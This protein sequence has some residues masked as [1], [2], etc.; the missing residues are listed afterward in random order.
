MPPRKIDSGDFTGK[1]VRRLAEAH[2]EDIAAAQQRTGLVNQVVTEQSG[3]FDAETGLA[4]ELTDEEAAA[5]EPE[6]PDDGGVEEVVVT[7]RSEVQ[8]PTE[9]AEDV[10]RLVTFRVNSDIEDMTYG[11]GSKLMNFRPGRVYRAPAYL[12]DHLANRGLLYTT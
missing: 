11:A 7:A 4:V 8:E 5:L 9:P 3:V 10:N 1:E 2:K 6:I 12:R